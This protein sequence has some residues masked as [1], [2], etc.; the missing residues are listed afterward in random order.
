MTQVLYVVRVRDD[1]TGYVAADAGRV[2]SEPMPYADAE[3][4]RRASPN[5]NQMTTE[6]AI[7]TARTTRTKE[8]DR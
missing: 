8:Q 4:I 6:P 7:H 5:G 2:L 1:A 3:Q